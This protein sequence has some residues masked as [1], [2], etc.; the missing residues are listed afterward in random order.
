MIRKQIP[1]ADFAWGLLAVGSVGRLRIASSLL[2]DMLRNAAPL[3]SLITYDE[4]RSRSDFY[5]APWL[6]M[7]VVLGLRE[8]GGKSVV[9]VMTSRRMSIIDRASAS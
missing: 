4:T 5:D 7:D 6:D 8:R 1:I 3:S 2:V 9:V